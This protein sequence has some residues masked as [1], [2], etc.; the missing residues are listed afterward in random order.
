MLNIASSSSAVAL[1]FH[2]AT[3]GIDN[4]KV[5]AA[6]FLCLVGLG[7]IVLTICCMVS[8]SRDKNGRSKTSR[9]GNARRE[10]AE[11]TYYSSAPSAP[12]ERLTKAE[13]AAEA[14]RSEDRARRAE[15]AFDREVTRRAT[16]RRY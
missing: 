7:V 13:W 8:S 3:G 9:G 14:A 1:T 10:S 4:S 15:V 11:Q 5:A 16:R 6:I 12:P 2:N